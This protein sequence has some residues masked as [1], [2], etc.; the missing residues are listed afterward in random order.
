TS[1]RALMQRHHYVPALYSPLERLLC[2]TLVFST[3]GQRYLRVGLAVPLFGSVACLRRIVADEG[4]LSPDQVILTEVYSTG[5]HRSFFDEDDLTCI[6]ENDV[7]Y[8]F[9]APLLYIRGGSARI[10][11]SCG[12]EEGN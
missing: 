9:Q 4:K 7:I 1:Q 6:A 11:G 5:F 12:T 10:S 3:K 2:V 8:A